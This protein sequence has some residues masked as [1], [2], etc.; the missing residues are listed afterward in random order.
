ISIA[1]LPPEQAEEPLTFERPLPLTPSVLVKLA[2]A[3]E[4]PGIHLGVWFR[5]G[6]SDQLHV[7]GTARSIPQL[8]FVLE[9][10]EPGLLVVK[11]RRT[12]E[13]GKYVNVVMLKG[14]QIKVIDERGTELVD[15]PALLTALLSFGAQSSNED[16]NVLVQLAV[17]MRAHGRGGLLLVVPPGS[18]RWR[19]S[20]L[21]PISYA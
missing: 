3:V 20:I 2:P 21:Q 1:F 18:D 19:E 12:R 16:T 9:V 15:C 8:C 14:D 6:E 4:R 13:T 5:N 17:S 7:W 11:N 10:I